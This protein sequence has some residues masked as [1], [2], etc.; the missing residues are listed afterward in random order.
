MLTQIYNGHVLTSKGWL[1]G[2]SVIFNKGRIIEISTD[3]ELTV[4]ATVTAFGFTS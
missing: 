2:A 3:G 1:N 4:S